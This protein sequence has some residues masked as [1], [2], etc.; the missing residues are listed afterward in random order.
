MTLLTG[1]NESC[2]L[3]DGW[4]LLTLKDI[5]ANAKNSIKRGPFGSTIK[6]EH[7]VAQGFKIYEQKNAIYNNFNLGTYYI[8]EKRFQDLKDFELKS[9]DV[10][11]S[12]SGTI[13]KIAIAPANIERGI[14]NQALL[15]I[16]LNDSLIEPMFF[17]YLFSS[18]LIQKEITSNTRGSAITNVSSVSVLK[19]IL[20]PVPPLNEQRRII[21]KIE[22]LFD[23]S[24]TAREAL[25]KIPIVLSKFRQLI[26][27]K[28][29][30]GE[31]T[32]NN[33]S[34]EPAQCLINR[35]KFARNMKTS[36][37]EPIDF[38]ANKN[39]IIPNNWSWSKIGMLFEVGLGSTPA[40]DRPVFWNG[41]IPWVSSSEVAFCRIKDTREKITEEGLKKTHLRLRRPGTILLAMIGEGKT[42]GQ[43]AILDIQASTNQNVAS[44]I[45]DQQVASEYIYY[46]LMSRYVVTR[47]SG[48]GGAQ[49]ALNMQRVKQIPIPIAP[50]KEQECIVN[51]IQE[52][53][54]SIEKIEDL[55]N[56]ARQEADRIN[57]A[58]LSKAF[59]GALVPQD[60]TDEPASELLLRL[61]AQK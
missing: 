38:E 1:E 53:F 4:A 25:N 21:N 61:K 2:K 27:D 39:Q 35:I 3:P 55:T 40:R 28:A 17:V 20:F 13:G 45:P 11:I 18:N 24:K 56:K 22:V 57:Q 50:I 8:D 37:E 31:L 36:I 32:E 30:K 46:W 60:P 29:F 19:K 16:T 10:I 41:N 48:E 47:Q 5:A 7:F 54:V 12:C 52:L 49:P 33:S 59:R 14:I 15:K 58:I 43:C 42:R 51:R 44:I 26:L 9:G 34:D 23:E 6:K